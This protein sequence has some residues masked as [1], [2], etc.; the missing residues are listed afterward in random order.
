MNTYV[1]ILV[2]WSVGWFAGSLVGWLVC[3]KF[4]KEQELH[5]ILEVW[6]YIQT[7]VF[8]ND[9]HKVNTA[10][11]REL[12]INDPQKEAYSLM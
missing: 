11:K 1:R 12:D 9:F 5:S 3:H 6:S 4:Q 8:D 2:R 7:M 10:L